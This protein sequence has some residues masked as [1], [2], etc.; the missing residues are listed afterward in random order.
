M[1]AARL[2]ARLQADHRCRSCRHHLL[3]PSNLTQGLR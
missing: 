3:S 2:Q 1:Q